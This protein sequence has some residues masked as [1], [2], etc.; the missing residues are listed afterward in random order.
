MLAEMHAIDNDVAARH[1]LMQLAAAR[2]KETHTLGGEFFSARGL[3]AWQY[4]VA[5]A[6]VDLL[7][8]E[9]RRGLRLFING[10]KEGVP[11]RD[12]LQRAYGINPEELT[13]GYGRSIRVP[14]LTP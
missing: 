7:L 12:S 8:R 3:E 2:L 5:S 1:S 4:G 10:I 13:T 11:W 14:R 6:M 9:D